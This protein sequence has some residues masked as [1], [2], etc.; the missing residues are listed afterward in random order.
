MRPERD[1]MLRICFT[2]GSE[3]AI[4]FNGFGVLTLNNIRDCIRRPVTASLHCQP[5]SPLDI[6][7]ACCEPR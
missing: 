6:K 3:C 4:M 7:E 5:I 2:I 1:K